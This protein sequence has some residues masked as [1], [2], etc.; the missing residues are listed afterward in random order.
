MPRTC[1]IC[2]H[3]AIKDINS[4]LVR[5][6][7]YRDIAR[8]HG[9]SKDALRRHKASHLPK[10]LRRAKDATNEAQAT[11]LLAEL[12]SLQAKSM[13]ILETA[14]SSGNLRVALTAIRE[15]RSTLELLAKLL[16]EL[17]QEGTISIYTNPEWLTLRA[18]ILRSVRPHPGAQAAML[19]ALN[20]AR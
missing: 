1:T 11:D 4:A 9:V 14:E 5:G 17:Q 2:K 12:R 6:E 15:T 10:L 13:K 8:Q 7:P 19:E 20:E 18:T 16:G 3:E